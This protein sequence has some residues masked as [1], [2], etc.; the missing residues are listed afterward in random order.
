MKTRKMPGMPLWAAGIRHTQ[1]YDK[2]APSPISCVAILSR[3]E[4]IADKAGCLQ[5]AHFYRC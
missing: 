4:G 2:E 3:D 5:E 1:I